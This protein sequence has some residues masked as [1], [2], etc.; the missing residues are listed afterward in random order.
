M[1]NKQIQFKK[2]VKQKN[3]VGIRRGKI[4]P[5]PIFGVLFDV[6][7]H[8]L[9]LQCLEEFHFNGYHILRTN[10]VSQLIF[11]NYERF[12]KK[13]LAKEKIF[14]SVNMRYKVNIADWEAA[15]R[16]LKNCQINIIVERERKKVNSFYIGTIE[17]VEEKSVY[18]RH[19]DAMG[20]WNKKPK[21]IPCREI[22]KVIFNDEYIN[23]FSK[24][25]I[26]RSA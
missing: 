6:N 20:R 8:L 1:K 12:L 11:R 13:I 5:N 15:F 24:H 4:D 2:H 18:M 26:N 9:L 22:T 21:I 3:V 23:I 19:F 16:S 14:P 7:S 17:K 25:T 10:D